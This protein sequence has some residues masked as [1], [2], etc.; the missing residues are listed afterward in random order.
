MQPIL[1]KF[2][3][4]NKRHEVLSKNAKDKL[5]AKGMGACEDL[6][7]HRSKLLQVMRDS[8]LVD[9]VCVSNGK[10]FAYK[11]KPDGKFAKI[12]CITTPDD[13]FKLGIQAV[14]YEQQGL[15]KY[16]VDDE[17]D[18]NEDMFD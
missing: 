4:R 6:T 2:V 15:T 3:R 17:E 9:S 13:L 1:V 10:L 16:M 7:P 18:N 14:N 11:E 8:D 5:R 12:G